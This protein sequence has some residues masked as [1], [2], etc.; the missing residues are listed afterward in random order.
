MRRTA[1]KTSGR[2]PTRTIAAGLVA[3]RVPAAWIDSES[4]LAFTAVTP[5]VRDSLPLR[6]LRTK[7]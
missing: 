2:A 3:R 1:S 6:K 7:Q 5:R 4:G